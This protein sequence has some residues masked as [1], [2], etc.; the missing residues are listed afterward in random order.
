SPFTIPLSINNMASGLIAIKTGF[1]GPSLATV[2][3]CATSNHAIGEAYTNIAHG[4]TDAIL[5]GGAE[6][7]IEPLYFAGFSKMKAMST[8]NDNPEKASRP[9][10]VNRDGFVMAEGAGVL[11]LEAAE[12]AKA[13]GAPILGGIV[14][15]GGT[16]V[17]YHMSAADYRGAM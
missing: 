5:A 15:Y 7:T 17:A 11:F 4:Y 9:F 12:H 3:A 2:S 8:N 14:G 13:R 6:A 16:R 1:T 10:D